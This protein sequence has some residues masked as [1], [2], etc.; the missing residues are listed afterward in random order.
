MPRRWSHRIEALCCVAVVA[1][2]PCFFFL[3]MVTEGLWPWSPAPLYERAPWEEADD[4]SAPAPLAYDNAFVHRYLPWYAFIAASSA[5]G[6]SVLWNPYEGGGAPFFAGWE[7][8]CLSPF[9]LP[10][11]VL[12][13]EAAL[14]AS[15]LAKA[16][17]AGLTALLAARYFGLV[18]PA[19]LLTAITFQTAPIVILANA[20]P[21]S[22]AVPWLPL[23]FA[24]MDYIKH[25][26]LLG[27]A[28][29]AASLALMLLGGAP[30]SAVF[31]FAT[32]LVYWA[33]V[34]LR[35]GAVVSGLGW[36][37]AGA[38]S[39]AF[40]VGLAAIQLLPAAE[41][42][43]VT[44]PPGDEYPFPR[45]G[46]SA[47]SA[48]LAPPSAAL[49]A[50]EYLPALLYPG[51]VAIALLPLWF[52]VRRFVPA[53]QRLAFEPMGL[54]MA[55]IA[56]I[57]GVAYTLVPPSRITPFATPEHIVGGFPFVLALL[58]AAAVQE[59]S[60]LDAQE[61]RF[62][63]RRLAFYVPLTGAVF[64]AAL[65]FP[66]APVRG[67]AMLFDALLLLGPYAAVVLFLAWTLLRP[68]IR[69]LG[70]GLAVIAAMTSFM[71]F[72]PVQRF[73]EPAAFFPDT[74]FLQTL[75][76]RNARVSGTQALREWPLSMAGVA[77]LYNPAGI[78][79]E[80]QRWFVEAAAKDPLLIRRSGSQALLLTREDI[81]GVFAAVRPDLRIE[82]VFESG[83]VLFNDLAMTS[84]ARM[85]YEA[86]PIDAPEPELL[87]A[88]APPLAENPVSPPAGEGPA[89][90]PVIGSS[91]THTRIDISVPNTRPGILVVSDA[92]YPGW[93][94]RVDGEDAPIFPVD[95]LFRGV[96]L[97]PGAHDVTIYY[98]P[99]SVILGGAISLATTLVAGLAGIRAVRRRRD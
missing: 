25:S 93:R 60:A 10:L 32:A 11:Y 67:T 29:F 89:A 4:G 22:D 97:G 84:R 86:R 35:I 99:T 43:A 53:R 31:L 30:A 33:I 90:F 77:Q 28:A 1:A 96:T 12:P 3:P 40:A 47:I 23:A 37:A 17:A 13:L 50:A 15:V 75:S 73:T 69:N 79:T 6:E 19:A 74:A 98:A 52:S 82:R 24:A 92:F 72:R 46:L 14:P 94:A 66:G 57:W 34:A 64:A 36:I 59:W 62:A 5:S 58:A 8:R 91:E 45:L 20:M 85:A 21:V 63:L 39:A 81:R 51:I 55:L 65:V 80:R 70:Y 38:G 27:S 71:A 18:W 16:I 7:T 2:A 54:A 41:L 68:S 56:G 83:A 76:E 87:D 9:S 49:A 44:A 42:I 48:V 61:T 88:A 95:I 26:R 78:E